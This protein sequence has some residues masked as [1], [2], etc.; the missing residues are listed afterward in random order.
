MSITNNNMKLRQFVISG[1]SSKLVGP[2]MTKEEALSAKQVGD[3]CFT[4]SKSKVK[5]GLVSCFRLEIR[6]S[7]RKR[8]W[9]KR[10][11]LRKTS[12]QVAFLL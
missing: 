9:G 2:H 10:F 7:L 12:R 4:Q 8:C 3:S 1:E 5:D 6:I 11:F